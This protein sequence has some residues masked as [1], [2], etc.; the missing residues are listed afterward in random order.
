MKMACRRLHTTGRRDRTR[1][2]VGH[3]RRVAAVKHAL[4][5]LLRRVRVDAV[6]RRRFIKNDVE[7]EG[8]LVVGRLESELVL[9]AGRRARR[10]FGQGSH[11]DGDAHPFARRGRRGFF[12]RGAGRVWC[13]GR[14]LRL[15][16]LFSSHFAFREL[17]SRGAAAA[18]VL[19]FVERC[20]KA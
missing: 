7:L 6:L 8:L 5:E 18:G 2:A 10:A 15:L 13:R 9:L 1:L 12:R 3:D 16:I 11:A 4:D 17:V 20:E 19:V 14:V